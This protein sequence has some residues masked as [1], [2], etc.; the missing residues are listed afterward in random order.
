MRLFL[1][2][3]I[4][5][6][7][8]CHHQAGQTYT[9]ADW[10]KMRPIMPRGYV[11]YRAKSPITIDGKDDDPAWADAPWTA[12]FVD[13]QDHDKPA[14]RFRTRAKMLWDDEYLYVYAEL[15]EPDVWGTLHFK[16]S[17]IFNDN[18]FEVFIDPN[19]DN[20]NYYEYEMNALNTIWE[21]TLEKPYRDG[22]PAHLGT[23][24]AGLKSA[25]HVRGTLNDPR[26]VDQGWSVEIALP[27]KDFEPYADG[28]SCP[29]RD[30]DQWRI[31]FSRVEWLVKVKHDTYHKVP[32]SKHDEDNWVW[33]PTGVIDMH[34]PERWGY[35]QFSR[36]VPGTAEF[37]PDPMLP[38]RD[39]LMTI[40]YLQRDYKEK[41]KKYAT[42]MDELK[43]VAPGGQVPPGIRLDSTG[44]HYVAT[45]EFQLSN[46][47]PRVFHV[48]DDSRLWTVPV[49]NP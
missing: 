9:S 16:N 23:N 37:R 35:V 10:A 7:V 22:G 3:G 26:D 27:W 20:V 28:A 5:T 4:L 39:E 49:L 17:I 34:R 11:A 15:R 44:D 46:G 8:G 48:E 38:V 31:D 32:K 2:L 42:T 30:G 45:K 43:E 24:M 14:P 47:S 41:H 40:Y 25:V 13:I 21:L 29:P 6:L 18:D 36:A 33:S 1:C 12:D 19:G